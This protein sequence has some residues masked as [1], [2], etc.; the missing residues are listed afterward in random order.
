MKII[1]DWCEL[2]EICAAMKQN[3]LKVV[4]TNG[5][6]D[7]IHRGHVDYLQKARDLGDALIIG[8]NSDASVRQIKGDKRPIVNQHDRAF[9]LA[10]LNCVDY[11]TFF[12]ES[13]PLALIKTIHPSV[14]V[15]GGD[16]AIHN[17][18]G[19]EIVEQDGGYVTTIPYLPGYSTTDLIG[20]IL[21][22]YQ[23]KGF[24]T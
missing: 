16:W 23:Q 9:V 2:Q 4:F 6:F 21:E 17:I 10:A 8:L 11:V 14:L 18:V 13:T 7:I 15:K 19:R 12:N 3:G 22:T 1:T 24:V 5:V 20:K